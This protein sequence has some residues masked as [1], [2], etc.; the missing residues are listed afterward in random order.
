MSPTPPMHLKLFHHYPHSPY[1]VNNGALSQVWFDR[2]RIAQ[3]ACE[4]IDS[5]TSAAECLDTL[6][7]EEVG[8]QG[9]AK[10]RIVVG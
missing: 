8:Q 6:I 9:I 2:H 7:N 4:Q 10:D 1:T 5:M 3:N